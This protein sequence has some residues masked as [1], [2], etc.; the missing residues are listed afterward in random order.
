MHGLLE[1]EEKMWHQRSRVQWL[2]CGDQNTRFFHGTATCRKRQNFIKGLRDENGV[3]QS[4]EQC[5]SGL[6]TDFYEKLF[7]SSNPH[8]MDRVVDGVQ[9]VV[10]N[11]MNADLTKPYSADEVERAIKDMV[12][13]KAPGPDG[14]P[15]LLY[16]TYWSDVGMDT[17]RAVLSCL[18]SGSIL[19]PINHTFITLILKV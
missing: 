9:K 18:N 12:P 10:T 2:Q 8:N 17:T 6:L 4:K 3:W 14:M 19:K 5:L 13:L 16:Q 11:S 7:K 1:K 15:P